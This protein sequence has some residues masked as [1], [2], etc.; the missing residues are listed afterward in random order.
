MAVLRVHAGM[1][2]RDIME[3]SLHGCR[4]VLYYLTETGP[5]ERARR[6][7]RTW[8]D[9]NLSYEALRDMFPGKRSD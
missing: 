3:T 1:S 5:Y 9:M 4:D 6:V 2:V 8:D 7:R